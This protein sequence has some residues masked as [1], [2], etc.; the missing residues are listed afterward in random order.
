MTYRFKLQEPIADGVRRIGLEQLD[1]AAAKL[2]GKKDDPAVA[3]HDA[4]RCLKRLR[5]LLRLV[6]PGLAET[7]YRRETDRL[8]GIGRM[9]AGARDLHVMQ[10]TLG[11]LET[12]FGPLPNG[13]AGHVRKLLAQG[14]I[15]R[16]LAGEDAKRRALSRLEQARR[17]FGGRAVG[18][19]SLE[20]I[21]E[22]LEDTYRKARKAFRHAYEKPSDEAFHAWRKKV[23]QHWRHMSLLS[24]GWPEAMSA[25]ASEAKELSRLLGDDHDLAVLIAFVSD[26]TG[27]HLEAG[28][29]EALA[30]L[31]RTCQD[32]LRAQARP[33][34]ERLFAERP[35]DLEERVHLY[36]TNAACLAA[37][38][39]AEAVP[40]GAETPAE[41]ERSTAAAPALGAS[42]A[43]RRSRR[44]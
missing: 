18:A 44:R 40:K 3:I 43:V 32:E 37:L 12:R 39:R 30:K 2:A 26:Q 8:V 41:R 19:I 34:G 14:R 29:V 33:R 4:R 11:K 6:R 1:I 21:A 25:R 31:C 36:W 22:G 9:L 27:K 17:L 16:R 35:Q 7:T 15:G 38:A 13:A 10:Q 42:P 20:H 5:A 24:R 23:Q 28:D